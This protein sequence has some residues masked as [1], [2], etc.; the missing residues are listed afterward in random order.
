MSARSVVCGKADSAFG[1]QD[2]AGPTGR[3]AVDNAGRNVERVVEISGEM[4]RVGQLLKLAGA[5][6]DGAGA[7][8]LIAA[9]KVTVNGER[10][11]RRG[12]QLRPGDVV[13]VG[14]DELRIR[15][16]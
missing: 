15:A 5:A 1:D 10:E 13:R 8:A 7:K 6:N 4:I 9:G 2:P 11:L 12:R 16:S 14:S 3:S